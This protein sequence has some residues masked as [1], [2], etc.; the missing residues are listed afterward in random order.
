MVLGGADLN[1]NMVI[2]G[3]WQKRVTFATRTCIY[4]TNQVLD[5][6]GELLTMAGQN[7]LLFREVRVFKKSAADTFPM[8]VV[9]GVYWIIEDEQWAIGFEVLGKENSQPETANVALAQNM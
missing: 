3:V 6:L 2:S 7:N 1:S 9:D 8:I 5:V 4:Y